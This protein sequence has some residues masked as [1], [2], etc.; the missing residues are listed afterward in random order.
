MYCFSSSVAFPGHPPEFF[1]SVFPP[2][3]SHAYTVFVLFCFV[4]GMF[5]VQPSASLMWYLSLV[6]FLSRFLQ[7]SVRVRLKPRGF[8]RLIGF[9]SVVTWTRRP[10]CAGS[11]AAGVGMAERDVRAQAAGS[12]LRAQL[13]GVRAFRRGMRDGGRRQQGGTDRAA[14][15]GVETPGGVFRIGLGE[16]PH[17]SVRARMVVGRDVRWWFCDLAV[18]PSDA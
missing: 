13:R 15:D 11:A 16:D 4:S 3:T 5:P 1:P 12:W 8:V 9:P 18:H 10:P 2:V 17:P 7:I 14:R 6:I